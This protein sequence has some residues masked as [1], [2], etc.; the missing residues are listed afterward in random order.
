MSLPNTIVMQAEGALD[1]VMASDGSFV[2][3][4]SLTQTYTYNNGLVQT[5]S[6]V[7]N[8]N[9]YTQTY[10]YSGSVLQSI[11]NWVH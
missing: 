10:T 11:S 1:V 4:S 6:V 8:G 2:P 3:I 9:T 7:W 5:V